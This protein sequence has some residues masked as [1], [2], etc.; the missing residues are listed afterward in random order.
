M[1]RSIVRI[2]ARGT[3]LVSCS[4]LLARTVSSEEVHVSKVLWA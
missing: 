4:P 1:G 3:G 2:A